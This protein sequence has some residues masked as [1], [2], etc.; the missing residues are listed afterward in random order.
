[1]RQRDL[2]SIDVR[3]EVEQAFRADMTRRLKGTVWTSGCNSWYLTPDGEVF[4]WPGFTF[5]YWRRTRTANLADYQLETRAGLGQPRACAP[6]PLGRHG[7]GA[8]PAPG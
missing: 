4:L 5:D 8:R 7:L 1:M 3:P 6:P 2:A